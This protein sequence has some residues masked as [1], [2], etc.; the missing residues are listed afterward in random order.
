MVN[1]KINQNK[2]KIAII[3]GGISGLTSAML[4]SK[5]Y[6]VSLYETNNYLGGHALTLNEKVLKNN[7]LSSVK[8]DVGFLVYN[9]KNYPIFSSI[10]KK[11][12]VQTLKSDMSFTVSNK[13][14][15]FEYGS[16]GVLALTNDFKNIFRYSFWKM[17]FG[18][19]KFYKISNMIL[20]SDLF[21][22]GN[23]SVNKFI[24]KYNFSDV[25]I[26]EHFLPMCGAIWSIPLKKVLDMPIITVLRF[27]HN[28]GLLSFFGKPK[29]MTINNG[30]ANY[31]KAMLKK[32]QGPIYLNEEVFSVKRS[33]D[34]ILIKSK[35]HKKSYDKVI[36][37]IHS[38][39]ILKILKDPS[40][41]EKSIL[42]NCK[43]ENN[44]I[45]VHQDQNLMPNNKNVWGAWNVITN[46]KKENKSIFNIKH[47]CVTYW[48]N[49]LQKIKSDAP[50][51]VTLNP[52]I[53]NMPNKKKTIKVLNFRHPIFNKYSLNVLDNINS[54]QGYK[55]TYYTGAWLGYGFHED[56]ARS[57]AN[58]ANLL[59]KEKKI[60]GSL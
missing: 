6:T 25:F 20:E 58:I 16:T 55:N 35:N 9:E 38:D 54:V 26:N 48:I 19:N 24:K 28:H 34:S 51:L 31:V 40:E 33:K 13:N 46:E 1:S 5:K 7:V 23:A 39:D 56:G 49:K 57:G 21:R 60:Y 53:E 44:K 18:I 30:S 17:F 15:G 2:T 36:F 14:K 22:E 52:N 4:L 11:L 12:K 42:S 50:I 47:I 45:Y 29:W 43:Y 3:G 8:F 10:L 32:I 41:K 37:S 59:N 27:F